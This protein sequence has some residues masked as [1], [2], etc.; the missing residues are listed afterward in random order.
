MKSIIEISNHNANL[1]KIRYISNVPEVV[2]I[3][4]FGD[5]ISLNRLLALELPSQ[6][7]QLHITFI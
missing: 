5:N 6:L 2:F 7:D 1:K 3:C 4:W